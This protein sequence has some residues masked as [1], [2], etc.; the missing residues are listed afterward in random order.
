MFAELYDNRDRAT[1]AVVVATTLTDASGKVVFRAEE[2]VEAFSFEPPRKSWT[3]RVEIPLADVQRGGHVLRVE[4]R[5]KGAASPAVYRE[6]P[7]EVG[8][9]NQSIT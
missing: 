1:E 8:E 6:V 2:P 5:R 4:A 7:L 3:H 9:M